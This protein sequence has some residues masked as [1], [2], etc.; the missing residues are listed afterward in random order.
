MDTLRRIGI[1]FLVLQSAGAALWWLVIC[2]SSSMRTLFFPFVTSRLVFI[3]VSVPDLVLYSGAGVLAAY[4]LAQRKRWV[5]PLVALHTGAA[6]YAGLYCWTLA[7][8][9]GSGWIGTVLMTPS[10]LFLPYLLVR[11]YHHEATSNEE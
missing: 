10:L 6:F 2:F 4:A 8:T 3:A 5:I 11:L 1:W 9:S 7:L